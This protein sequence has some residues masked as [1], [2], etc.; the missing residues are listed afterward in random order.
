MQ[1]H[2]FD[3]YLVWNDCSPISRCIWLTLLM[4]LEGPL[5]DTEDLI[6]NTDFV[7]MFSI[8][9]LLNQIAIRVVLL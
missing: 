4:D 3:T 6:V 5:L 1:D 7:W 9:Q 8:L 2:L